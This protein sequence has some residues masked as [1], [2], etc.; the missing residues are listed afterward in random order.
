MQA[1]EVLAEL[2]G[3]L[4]GKISKILV[5]EGDDLLLCYEEGE[6]ILAGVV[7]L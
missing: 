4:D 1:T 7:E 3:F 5:T 6:F 2:Q